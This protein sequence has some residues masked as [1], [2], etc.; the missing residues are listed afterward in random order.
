M[1][2]SFLVKSGT[3]IGGILRAS[4]SWPCVTGSGT[5]ASPCPETYGWASGVKEMIRCFQPPLTYV[6]VWHETTSCCGATPR[7]TTPAASQPTDRLPFSHEQPE[8]P[9]FHHRFPDAFFSLVTDHEPGN[10][11]PGAARATFYS[12]PPECLAPS[13]PQ[14]CLFLWPSVRAHCNRCRGR[15]GSTR[16]CC[17]SPWCPRGRTFR[18][19]NS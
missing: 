1:N 8:Q 14:Q 6:C 4:S 5:S 12:S 3:E 2:M 19:M 13:T 18:L 16:C 17:R 7:P 15:Y 9:E 10:G 11:A